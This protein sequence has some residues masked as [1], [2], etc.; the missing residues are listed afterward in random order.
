MDRKGPRHIESAPSPLVYSP[1]NASR[2][3]V[4]HCYTTNELVLPHQVRVPLVGFVH[5]GKVEIAI[6]RQGRREVVRCLWE[7]EN[8]DG[9]F[10]N[11]YTSPVELRAVEPTLLRLAPLDGCHASSLPT[12][13]FSTEHFESR[14]MRD[15][16][17]LAW[18]ALFLSTFLLL[19]FVGWC[20]PAPWKALLSRLAY[21]LAS[22]HVKN[23]DDARALSLLQL[24]T[25]LDPRL[26]RS[27]NDLG[28]IYYQEGQTEEAQAA[29]EGALVADP[30]L[31]VAQNNLG[32]VYLDA[33][34]L[35]LASKALNR[36]VTLDPENATAWANLGTVEL[37][38]GR[39]TEATHAYRAALRLSSANI[40]ARV[41]LGILLYEQGQ[42]SDARDLL[43]AAIVDRPDLPRIRLILGA[44]ALGEGDHRRAWNHFQAVAGEL[45]D[46]PLLHF[47]MALWY[48]EAGDWE[49]AR[50]QL[51]RAIELQPHPDLAAL[52]HSHLDVL[53]SCQPLLMKETEDE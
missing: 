10:W 15:K 30:M 21:S 47:Y 45:A 3:L 28:Y 12:R 52:V 33:G 46:D 44:I 8:L 19:I 25:D 51:N 38:E 34:E 27:Q 49:S 6:V 35:G 48:E 18:T 41:N 5:K 50:K 43:Q 13:S 7:N 32:L 24:S 29:F 40:A 4:P 17:Q 20:W 53:P 23:G 37:L 31:A 22:Y 42:L 11:S 14:A 16:Q 36:A 39:S 2:R 26:G 9:E 1:A